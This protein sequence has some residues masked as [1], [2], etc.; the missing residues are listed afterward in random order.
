MYR[1]EQ[2]EKLVKSI[3][4][5]R[6]QVILYLLSFNN[7][8]KEYEFKETI[9]DEKEILLVFIKKLLDNNIDFMI[10]TDEYCFTNE[11]NELTWMTY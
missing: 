8:L 11:N 10:S 9:I 6:E 2:Y 7:N 1:I 4:N 3:F 5:S